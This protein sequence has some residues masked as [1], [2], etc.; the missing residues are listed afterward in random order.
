MAGSKKSEA[1]PDIAQTYLAG[2]TQGPAVQ[3]YYKRFGGPQWF[4]GNGEAVTELA[5]VLRR[6]PLDG[7]AQGPSLADQVERARLMAS[8][9][10][11]QERAAAE[12]ILSAA[13]VTY[14]EAIQRPSNDVIFGYPSLVPPP[15]TAESVLTAAAAAPSLVQ[16]L[17]EVSSVNPMYAQLRD[18][19]WQQA[20]SNPTAI[21]DPRIVKNLSRLRSLPKTDR[22]ALVNIATQT[23]TMYENNQP[24]DSMKVIVGADDLP[25]PMISSVIYYAT[26]NPYWNVPD[27]LVRKTTA[28]SVMKQGKSYLTVRGYQVMSDWTSNA[29]EVSPDTI[30]WAAV[31]AGRQ[32]IRVRQNPSA[33]NSMG[34]L[35]FSFANGEGIFLHDTPSKALFNKSQRTL[36][37]GCVRL[38]DARRFGRWLLQK[39]PVAPSAAAEQ[40][41]PLPVGVPVYITYLTAQESNGK[42]AFLDDVYGWDAG[43]RF[44]PLGAAASAAR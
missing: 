22:F 2:F 42:I 5:K 26:F 38:E 33:Y 1:Q 18:A 23:L 31:A 36:S 34:K 15:A 14:V 41:V 32:T 8:S 40:F 29:T 44:K 37:N 25:T 4:A 11:K 17:A 9:K 6:A 21:P 28:P 7:L 12:Q 16:H 24:V 35:K 10:D 30:D 43:G 3:A 20:A 39:E 19:A 27:H 13:W